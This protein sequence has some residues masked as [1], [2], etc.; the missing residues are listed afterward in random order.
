MTKFLGIARSLAD[1][2]GM[3]AVLESRWIDF[4]DELFAK[5]PTKSQRRKIEILDAT[6]R[7]L[8]KNGIDSLRYADVAEACG[9][10]RNLIQHYFPTLE[11][12]AVSAL[13]AIRARFQRLAVE[14]I[15]RETSS[16]RMLGAYLDSTYDWVKNCP[17]EAKAW[18]LF[19]HYCGI[20]RVYRD[21]NTFLVRQGTQRIAALI[22]AG[23][24][25]SE[26]R[27]GED[28][29]VRAKLI[30]NI[31]TGDLLT[32]LTEEADALQKTVRESTARVCM[33]IAR[34]EVP[35]SG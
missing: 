3:S 13:Q 27:G 34:G 35:I 10:S 6:I 7:F 5:K 20:K 28:S 26:F 12:L 16:V 11:D 25:A 32:T 14:A 15:G 30:Q 18:L 33:A 22:D 23:I 1:D 19:Y 21:L 4:V 8:A 2:Q 31:L 29:L 17:T 24:R 9:V